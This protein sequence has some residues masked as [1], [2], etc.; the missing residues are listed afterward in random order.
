MQWKKQ[1]ELTWRKKMKKKKNKR[2]PRH[3]VKSALLLMS[4]YQVNLEHPAMSELII[5]ET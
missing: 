4:H 5:S 3:I 1:Y 2:C